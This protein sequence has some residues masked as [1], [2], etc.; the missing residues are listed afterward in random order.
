MPKL[1][2][3]KAIEY[4]LAELRKGT[5]KVDIVAKNGREWQIAERTFERYWKIA[6]QTYQ[7]EA[8]FIQ[9]QASEVIVQ[10]TIEGLKS[11][12]KSKMERLEQLQKMLDENVAE[13]VTF[14]KEGKLLKGLRRLTPSEIVSINSE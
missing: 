4:I 9:K 7:A 14:N 8:E 12:L 10:Q 13:I 5:A 6:Q 3:Q 11:G 1:S 2:K